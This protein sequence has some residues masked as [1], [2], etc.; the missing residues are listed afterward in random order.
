METNDQRGLTLYIYRPEH[1]DSSNGGVS[2]RCQRVTLVGVV[3]EMEG[4]RSE[5]RPFPQSSRVPSVPSPDAPAVVAVKRRMGREHLVHVEPLEE[6]VQSQGTPWMAG[7]TYVATSDSRVRDLLGADGFYGALAF[8]DRTE[9]WAQ[10]ARMS[11]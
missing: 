4:G 10:Y 8:H 2:S 5:M 6:P 7:G 3:T 1:G 11:N 9:S